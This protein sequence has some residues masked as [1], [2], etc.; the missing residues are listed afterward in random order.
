MASDCEDLQ[1]NPAAV[2][3]YHDLLHDMTMSHELVK[4]DG[5]FQSFFFFYL[6]T[7]WQSIS[8]N[9]ALQISESMVLFLR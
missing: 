4:P 5:R 6:G 8:I 3:I 2:F 7:P 9:C 1:Y